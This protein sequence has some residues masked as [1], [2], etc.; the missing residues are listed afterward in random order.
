MSDQGVAVGQLRAFVERV[1]RVEEEIKTLNDD[2]S[3]IYKEIRGFGFDVKAVRKVVAKRKLDP[4]VANEQDAV[5]DLYW[6]ALTGAS[7]VHVHEEGNSYAAEKGVDREA[8]RKQRLSESMDDNIAFSAEMVADGLISEEAHEET[9]RIANAVARKFGN[10]R[11]DEH[12]DP[13]TGE[14]HQRPSTNDKS[15]PEAGPQ[16]EASHVGTDTGMLADREGRHEGEAVSAD[17]PTNSPETANEAPKQVYGDSVAVA[18]ALPSESVNIPAGGEMQ[19]ES[20][21]SKNAP[22]EPIQP[23]QASETQHPVSHTTG[24]KAEMPARS[25]GVDS[26]VR[27]VRTEASAVTAGETAPDQFTPPAFLAQKSMRDYRPHC[28]RPDACGASGL[29]HC[30][31]CSKLAPAESEVA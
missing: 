14:I 19:S 25:G 3:E 23:E 24:V 13:E 27:V 21:G 26:M 28:Q 9:V 4:S 2:K 17:L 7:R 10:G 11:L 31:S 15:S 6:D 12:I 20:D 1:E 30:Y 22:A 8:R 29:K 16:A 18:T 5:F